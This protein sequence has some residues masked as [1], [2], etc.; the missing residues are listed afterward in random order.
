[1]ATQETR[2]PWIVQARQNEIDAEAARVA[3]TRA[4]AGGFDPS[5][6]P[7]PKG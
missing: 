5:S 4:A 1:M 3:R 7:K 6:R 2:E